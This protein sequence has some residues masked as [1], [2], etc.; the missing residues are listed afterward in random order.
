[1]SYSHNAERE[2]KSVSH[3][4][5]NICGQRWTEGVGVSGCGLQV[6]EVRL[7]SLQKLWDNMGKL[8]ILGAVLAITTINTRADFF[9]LLD[10]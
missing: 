4:C 5:A 1:M 3:L 6:S 8:I 9:F 2:N 7:T 10:G